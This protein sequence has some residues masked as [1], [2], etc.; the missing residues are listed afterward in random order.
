[1]DYNRKLTECEDRIKACYGNAQRAPTLNDGK[2]WLVKARK[3]EE[4][5]GLLELLIKRQNNAVV[6]DSKPN[7]NLLPIHYRGND[8]PA[9]V[10]TELPVHVQTELP[11]FEPL[12]S[13]PPM[14]QAE[15]I[16]ISDVNRI[17]GYIL[18]KIV[19]CKG[20][21]QKIGNAWEC[22][23][24]S[25]A[26]IFS[27]G[28]CY[29]EYKRNYQE[30]ES[31]CSDYST[32]VDVLNRMALENSGIQIWSEPN[33][34]NISI[35]FF[36]DPANDTRIMPELVYRPYLFIRRNDKLTIIDLTTGLLLRGPPIEPELEKEANIELSREGNHPVPIYLEKSIKENRYSE[37]I[38]GRKTDP[39]KLDL[40]GDVWYFPLW[41]I[42]LINTRKAAE[43]QPNGNG[44]TI[45]HLAKFNVK[46]TIVYSALD[47]RR[48]Y[49]E[50]EIIADPFDYETKRLYTDKIAPDSYW[51]DLQRK[52]MA[53]RKMNDARLVEKLN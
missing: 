41:K 32:L 38:E 3:L 12:D 4:F 24:G 40:D 16:K 46:G 1:M 51:A 11:V 25:T 26:E 35:D 18:P 17:K 10:R 43:V 48:L 9:P 30:V 49:N 6:A 39:I 20:I 45:V 13:E 36:K 15:V 28:F 53:Q 34:R 27:P 33:F 19:D 52:N 8:V 50:R 31:P 5:K 29:K 37:S 2:V 22:L 44:T 42:Q 23:R 14:I 47:G 21:L 7:N